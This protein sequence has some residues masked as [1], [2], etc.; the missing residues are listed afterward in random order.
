MRK[1]SESNALVTSGNTILTAKQTY[2]KFI[3]EITQ[4]IVIND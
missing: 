3:T 4:F 1:C 2:S